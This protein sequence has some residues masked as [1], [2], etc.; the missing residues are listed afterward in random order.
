[1]AD[2]D[3]DMSNDTFEG[4]ASNYF[5]VGVHLV[6]IDSATRRVND[7]GKSFVEVKFQ[8]VHDEQGDAK[9]WFTT[10]KGSK[11]SAR[12]INGIIVHN[13]TSDEAKEKAR[14][15]LQ[16]IKSTSEYDDKFLTKLKGKEAW[17]EVYEDTNAPKPNGGYYKRT[18]IYQYE[19]KPRQTVST[20]TATPVEG[21]FLSQEELDEIPF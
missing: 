9:L 8:G 14:A 15:V 3:L 21:K 17:I 18:D 1:M 5:D 11:Y 4:G 20:P 13:Q 2:F 12:V 6:M 19:P 16:K 10:E 7:K